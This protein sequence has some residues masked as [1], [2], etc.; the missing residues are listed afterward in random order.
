M[1]LAY[2]QV[3]GLEIHS[4]LPTARA[5]TG[6]LRLIIILS[7]ILLCFDIHVCCESVVHLYVLCNIQW[8]TEVFLP[9]LDDWERS[10]ADREGYSRSE[11]GMMLLSNETRVGLKITGLGIYRIV[12]CVYLQCLFHSAVIC[13]T[14]E[15]LV[16]SARGDCLSKQPDLSGPSREVFWPTAAARAS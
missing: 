6:N 4:S 15:T 10:V 12:F 9:Y 14:G 7:M 11:K 1:A 8:L 2:Q 13:G 3:D 5:Q 16:Y